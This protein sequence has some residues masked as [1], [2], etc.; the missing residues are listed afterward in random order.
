MRDT[1]LPKL[2]VIC[3]GLASWEAGVGGLIVAG[4]WRWEAWR[5]AR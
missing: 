2:T 5:Q 4:D 1:T 3:G